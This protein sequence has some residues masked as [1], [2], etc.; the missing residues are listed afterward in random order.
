M[1]WVLSRI[2]VS[3]LWSC[4]E[5]WCLQRGEARSFG[6][7]AL[8]NCEGRVVARVDG[9]GVSLGCQCRRWLEVWEQKVVPV[10][11]KP[12][13]EIW[14]LVVLKG[15]GG[16]LIGEIVLTYCEEWETSTGNDISAGSHGEEACGSTCSLSTGLCSE[17]SCICNLHSLTNNV[18]YTSQTA[19]VTLYYAMLDLKMA[20]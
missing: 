1:M 4:G 19:R 13:S 18:P 17:E 2:M 20:L 5:T 10:G 8:C 6:T 14:E 11:R 12:G 15:G 16:V 7:T 9:R 3:E